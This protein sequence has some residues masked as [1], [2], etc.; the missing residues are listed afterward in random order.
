MVTKMI[1]DVS[2][3]NATQHN[4]RVLSFGVA[5][6]SSEHKRHD[7]LDRYL[8]MHAPTTLKRRISRRIN[9]A[10]R[11]DAL[12]VRSADCRPGCRVRTVAHCCVQASQQWLGDNSGTGTPNTYRK[13][14]MVTWSTSGG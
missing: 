9:P 10:A 4:Y 7:S 3:V 5:T 13:T 14:N 2:S 12:S 11:G 6:P 8:A 1:Y